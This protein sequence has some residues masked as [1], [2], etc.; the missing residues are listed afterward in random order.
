[1]V[2]IPPPAPPSPRPVIVWSA[3]QVE[4]RACVRDARALC[5]PTTGGRPGVRSRRL[6]ALRASSS[7]ACNRSFDFTVKLREVS[8]TE[9]PNLGCG[10]RDQQQ[11]ASSS[12]LSAAWPPARSV[13]CA[14]Q[15]QFASLHLAT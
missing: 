11:L 8:R 7:P 2:Q 9:L 12:S 1:G 4:P 14:H 13:R 10:E 15:G 6:L 3:R 5:P